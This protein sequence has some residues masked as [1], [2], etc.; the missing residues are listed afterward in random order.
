MFARIGPRHVVR[1]APYMHNGLFDTLTGVLHLYARGGGD[2]RARDAVQA[3]NA[4]FRCAAQV[5]PHL[6]P[7]RLSEHDLQALLAFL[8]TL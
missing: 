1:T 4:L 8:Q 6:Q 3:Q 2:P 7:L 5:S